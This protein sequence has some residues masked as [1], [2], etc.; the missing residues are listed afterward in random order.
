MLASN[1]PDSRLRR[2][3][4]SNLIEDIMNEVLRGTAAITAALNEMGHELTERQTNH[5]LTTGALPA[6]KSGGRWETNGSSVH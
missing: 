4:C 2:V 1:R 5:M 6:W 3:F